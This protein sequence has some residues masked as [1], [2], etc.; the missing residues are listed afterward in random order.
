MIRSLAGLI[1][2]LS[3]ATAHAVPCRN[4]AAV[5]GTRQLAEAQCACASATRHLSYI[6]CVSRVTHDA[7]VSGALPRR[8]KAAVIH[9]A[10]RS[11]CGNPNHVVCCRTT[12]RGRTTCSIK[13]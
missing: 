7:I 6:S 5:A 1:A 13:R 4:P 12:A 11:V 10:Q 9:C 3:V 8:C 2:F